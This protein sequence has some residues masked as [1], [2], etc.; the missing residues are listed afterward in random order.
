MLNKSLHFLAL[1]ALL[2]PFAACTDDFPTGDYEIGEGEALVTASVD[3]HPL[4]ATENETG[5]RAVA[6]SQP[7]DLIK[8]IDDLTVFM[9]DSE[10]KLV[11]IYTQDDFVDY[12]VKKKGETGSNTDMPNDA[13]GKPVQS[14]ESTSRATF[15]IKNVPFGK[16]R[17]YAVA[18]MGFEDNEDTRER[19]TDEKDLR[20]VKVEWDQTNIAN[21]K[22]M[23]GYFTLAG[24]DFETSD[25]F[26]APVV[27]V[28]QKHVSLHSWIKR[29]ASK[30]TVVYDGSGLHEGIF[31]Y[32]KSITSKDS[33][34]YCKIGNEN[35][36]HTTSADSMIVDGG[37]IY[38]S[39]QAEGEMAP[40]QKPSDS[41]ESWM[42]IANGTPLRGA[43]STVNGEEVTHTEYDRALYFYE[44]CQGNYPGQKKYDKRQQWDEV[45]FNPKP[46]Q[47][48]YKDNIEYGTYVEVEAYYVSTNVNQ[49][50]N[51]P[52][53]YRFM[54]GQ[55]CE[56]DYDAFRNHHYKLTLGFRGYANQPDWH[57]EYVEPDV[58]FYTDPT[59]YVSYAYNNKAIFPVRFKGEVEEFD[60]EIVENNWAPYDKTKKDSV[61]DATVGTGELAFKWNRP[62]Y[63]NDGGNMWYGLQ[64]PWSRDGSKQQAPS[65][66]NAPQKVTP[67]WAGFLALQVPDNLEAVILPGTGT[68]YDTQKEKLKEYFY[69]HNQNWRT[70]TKADLSFPN[71]KQGETVTKTVGS[72]NNACEIVKAPDGSTT[73]RLTTWTRPKSMLGISGFTGNNPYD[74]Y[75]RKAVVK[76]TAKYKGVEKPI[77]KYMPIYQVRRVV[78][79]KAVWRQWDDNTSFNVKLYR[80]EGADAT[81][82]KTFESEG[83]WR[84]YVQTVSDGADGFISIT[85]GIGHDA[86][87]AIVGNTDTP[88]EFTINFNGKGQK[89]KSLCGI[90]R[91]E[92]HGYT[93]NHSIFVRQGYYEPITIMDN[94]KWSSFSLY[95]CDK[96]TPYQTQW[97]GK[98]NPTDAD[99]ISATVTASP[100]SLGTLFKR[101]N[102][103]EGILIENNANSK[104]G[105]LIAPGNTKFSLT[106]GQSKS[107]ADING[108]SFTKSS[109]NKQLSQKGEI[110]RDFKWSRFK[111]T[112]NGETRYYRVPTFEEYNSLLSGEYGI[113]VLYADGAT[114]PADVVDVAYGFEDF[115]NNGTDE[116]N[117]TTGVY[118]GKSGMRGFI[119]FNPTNAHQVFFPLGARGIGRRTIQNATDNSRGV[120]RYGAVA[121]TLTQEQNKINQYRPI[122]FNLPASPGAIYWI[123]Q[124]SNNSNHFMAWDMNYFDLNFLGYDYACSFYGG[125]DALPIKLVRDDSGPWKK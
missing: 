52:I 29:C 24:N 19:F 122:P 113:G 33:P 119:V 103:A 106:N 56:F 23:F 109:D 75:Q 89:G 44:N 42:R 88:V 72:G 94:A 39:E 115:D 84:A 58:T 83:A 123:E 13:G 54:L 121:A 32:I 30:V 25:G 47:Y 71:W 95:S 107:W 50:S 65:D 97:S 96:N 80:R 20:N 118:G 60:V 62:V 101:G 91:I 10:G 45:G 77:V 108:I 53:K 16:Y 22:Q 85:G 31:V 38:Y 120:L 46:G 55:N 111:A 28:S 90:I 86:D 11:D 104:L 1:L 110:G 27:P 21:N 114:E 67:I 74:T 17:M 105:P 73:V 79:P 82:F 102:Y 117:G 15:T 2:L 8:S 34:R 81:H 9:Y 48:D 125:G 4:V 18:N 98:A 7:G 57:I 61:P 100:L 51:G 37:V 5:G 43:V 40:G 87:G 3:F 12:S 68:T 26:D 49:V 14:E 124:H 70:F 78:N 35:A 36:V 112:V 93:C 64:T 6:G 76:L 92:Y 59:Y 99:Y 66:K 41:Y 63:M 69:E 116:S